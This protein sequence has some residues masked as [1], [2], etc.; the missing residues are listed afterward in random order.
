MSDHYSG[1]GFAFAYGDARLDFTDLYAY[2]K[3]G[4]LANRSG[5]HYSRTVTRE[6]LYELQI[7]TNGDA[8]TDILWSVRG[9]LAPGIP[10]LDHSGSVAESMGRIGEIRG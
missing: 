4:M 2:P 9:R 3:P 5:T 1:P 8:V 10:L 6:A 7:D